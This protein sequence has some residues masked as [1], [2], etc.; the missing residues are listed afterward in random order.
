MAQV[1]L[2]DALAQQVRQLTDDR[3]AITLEMQTLSVALNDMETTRRRLSLERGEMTQELSEKR[4]V[5]TQEL[6]RERSEQ[7]D[8]MTKELAQEWSEQ[9]AAM[10]QKLAQELPEQRNAMRQ[11][12][13]QELSDQREAKT[14]ELAQQL[15]QDLSEQQVDMT[16]ELLVL[17]EVRDAMT[18][19]LTGKRDAITKELLER[20]NIMRRKLCPLLRKRVRMTRNLRKFAG[21]M[22]TMKARLAEDKPLSSAHNYLAS[23]R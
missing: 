21:D 22:Q 6:A 20:R 2:R 10:T 12:I 15:A 8:A 17:S 9:R 23:D 3:E 14:Q 11:E 18:Q 19:E 4:K 16:Q 7:R 13:A 5:M 1:E